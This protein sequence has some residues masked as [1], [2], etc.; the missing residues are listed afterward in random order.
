M[1]SVNL[2]LLPDY[3]EL[4]D[5]NHMLAYCRIPV[6]G[7]YYLMWK[8][9]KRHVVPVS[10][11]VMNYSDEGV[12][13]RTDDLYGEFLTCIYAAK[14]AILMEAYVPENNDWDR[15]VVQFLKT[16]RSDRKIVLWWH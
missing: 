3:Y 15:A 4:R 10:V 7:Q 9:I 13:T 5:R 12:V 1:M 16:L 2:T 14:L 8:E 11:P 6:D